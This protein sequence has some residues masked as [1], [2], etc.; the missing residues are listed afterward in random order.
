MAVRSN[1]T[2]DAFPGCVYDAYILAPAHE[3]GIS[4]VIQKPCDSSKASQ[5]WSISNPDAELVRLGAEHPL[6]D[7]FVQNACAQAP[8][9]EECEPAVSSLERE[10]KTR[11]A[12]NG[13]LSA[14]M[15]KLHPPASL[16]ELSLSD[17][18]L[19]RRRIASA[20]QM[21]STHRG[22]HL[23]GTRALQLDF[24][25]NDFGRAASQRRQQTAAMR[26]GLAQ[27]VN[28]MKEQ[29]T[30]SKAGGEA[31]PKAAPS[32]KPGATKAKADEKKPA[33]ASK[34]V[35]SAT[36]ERI[37][38]GRQRAA[39]TAAKASARRTGSPVAGHK[40]RTA[41]D[42]AG[43][44]EAMSERP[45]TSAR[46]AKSAWRP[47][48]VAVPGRKIGALSETVLQPQ[49]ERTPPHVP[50]QPAHATRVP[51]SSHSHTRKKS[52]QAYY[53]Q[54]RLKRATTAGAFLQMDDDLSHSDVEVKDL[55]AP[56]TEL[57]RLRLRH[58]RQGI[59]ASGR[60]SRPSLASASTSTSL[61][62]ERERERGVQKHRLGPPPAH[63]QGLEKRRSDLEEVDTRLA[64]GKIIYYVKNE[65]CYKLRIGYRIL[66]K[67]KP[68]IC[69]SPTFADAN[70][71]A[72]ESLG[73]TADFAED[74]VT[75][76]AA[77]VGTHG[78]SC[79]CPSGA[80][81]QVGEVSGSDCTTLACAGGVA[82]VCS[83]AGGVWSRR[84]VTC[85][86]AGA[87]L[88]RT[89]I[90][91]CACKQTWTYEGVTVNDFC[92]DPNGLGYEWC[93]VKDGCTAETA[94]LPTGPSNADWGYCA[95][96]P[97]DIMADEVHMRAEERR[98]ATLTKLDLAAYEGKYL[99]VYQEDHHQEGGARFTTEGC[100][101]KHTWTW[102]HDYPPVM[103]YCAANDG[104]HRPYI[105]QQEGVP[106]SAFE[107]CELEDYSC[108]VD[109]PE[110][111]LRYFGY[112][113]PEG[114]G[115]GNCYELIVGRGIFRKPNAP[116]ECK[117]SGF[118]YTCT[119]ESCN[120]K[121]MG[122]YDEEWSQDATHVYSG[123][124][125]NGTPTVMG[126]ECDGATA[127]PTVRVT[128]YADPE[129]TELYGT[130]RVDKTSCTFV[131]SLHKPANFT[132]PANIKTA[133][134]EPPPSGAYQD[135]TVCKYD[136][137]AHLNNVI[138]FATGRALYAYDPATSYCYKTLLGRSLTRYRVSSAD[139]CPG[140]LSTTL[141]ELSTQV[142][143]ARSG[144]Y[145]YRVAVGDSVK[146]WKET[147]SA[148]CN[149]EYWEETHGPNGS[150]SSNEEVY[151]LGLFAPDPTQPDKQFYRE[152]GSCGSNPDRST[153]V[154]IQNDPDITEVAFDVS[155]STPCA[156]TIQMSY[157]GPR[158]PVVTQEWEGFYFRHPAKPYNEPDATA[159]TAQLFS[160]ATGCEVVVSLEYRD[161]INEPSIEVVASDILPLEVVASDIRPHPFLPLERLFSK[162]SDHHDHRRRGEH[163]AS[164]VKTSLVETLSDL[165]S[166]L[167]PMLSLERGCSVAA[168]KVL[169]PFSS[170]VAAAEHAFA[171]LV[172]GEGKH[173]QVRYSSSLAM[174]LDESA[175]P[176]AVSITLTEGDCALS[177]SISGQMDDLKAGPMMSAFD[178][179]M[180]QSNI[181]IYSQESDYGG[182]IEGELEDS[183]RAQIAAAT[184]CCGHAADMLT[185]ED[186]TDDYGDD[187]M[188]EEQ[189][190]LVAGAGGGVQYCLRSASRVIQARSAH[191]DGLLAHFDPENLLAEG[192]N[193]FTSQCNAERLVLG[194][195]CNKSVELIDKTRKNLRDL[196]DSPIADWHAFI[197]GPFITEY[198]PAIYEQLEGISELKRTLTTLDTV[199]L[200]L[201]FLPGVGS[202][203][204]T[205]KRAVRAFKSVLS[206][207]EKVFKKFKLAISMVLESALTD[208][209]N[210]DKL[211]KVAFYAKRFLRELQAVVHIVNYV[212]STNPGK[213][214]AVCGAEV[215]ARYEVMVAT[216]Q[217]IVDDG[218]KVVED[219]AALLGRLADIGNF[220]TLPMWVG[221]WEFLD[222]FK[223]VLD[224]FS[225]LLNRPICFPLPWMKMEYK[226]FNYW[227]LEC[228]PWHSCRWKKYQT[229]LRVP[230]FYIK[231]FC[232][233]VQQI[234]NGLNN[235][236]QVVVDGLNW[237]VQQALDFLGIPEIPWP[238]L[239]LDALL[240]LLKININ[241]P[242]FPFHMPT[243]NHPLLGLLDCTM[244]KVPQEDENLERFGQMLLTGGG[245]LAGGGALER[246]R[247]TGRTNAQ[248]GRR[249]PNARP[250]PTAVSP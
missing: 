55:Q 86:G 217:K 80:V 166:D 179:A 11:K 157:P 240:E 173:E 192:G 221:F 250:L 68:G 176:G 223:I 163:K 57:Q 136:Y 202:L 42:K 146:Q 12:A 198:L 248:S 170:P 151:N 21:A 195:A 243:F 182:E 16:R 93:Y 186:E 181:E 127:T 139:D 4:T 75:E 164:A 222:F 149:N 143:Y 95:P 66:R 25:P 15:L 200:P 23:A 235:L 116:H 238:D 43:A 62:R 65:Y 172:V 155:E 207:A 244:Q 169:W 56:F 99:Y 46:P 60:S 123:G 120:Y 71:E 39:T 47:P 226:C 41:T 206:P 88:V 165:E 73:V 227:W 154:T 245:A 219:A 7:N 117:G 70:D 142:F 231:Q 32:Q 129:A 167:E 94:G 187:S 191:A 153:T 205:A 147:S 184:A 83:K 110:P 203:F 132:G 50:P 152:G 49:L 20:R 108:K 209:D 19:R 237:L 119:D 96:N 124:T 53:K 28:A 8:E 115:T 30:H 27:A 67:F 171:P 105:N 214:E 74:V 190:T 63:L 85:G 161:E 185:G 72:I 201:T 216:A 6:P 133:N 148:P 134:I 241:W 218:K 234:L 180:D 230:V 104:T 84:S 215:H 137:H 196:I 48:I 135:G 89:T 239:G 97:A 194:D 236:V 34:E 9:G 38:A 77:G 18:A 1:I 211:A 3:L 13:P 249:Q 22:R 92:G 220:F 125:T 51:P 140:V 141:A 212:Y 138:D 14:A 17:A 247:N 232:F 64:S 109:S 69:G 118:A 193:M 10:R 36:L 114:R 150:G 58:A 174:Y 159:N 162:H 145:C 131:V 210:V 156:Y 91:G 128:A 54:R 37:L 82:G 246:A 107:L 213:Q 100:A 229:C 90:K 121:V 78:G 98:L 130:V 76:N 242:A 228:S 188:A 233:T 24:R 113:G 35:L 33:S 122:I 102:S 106:S 5:Q 225:W 178:C 189:T 177:F 52:A 197:S 199:L 79:T 224:P 175:T 183:L 44:G 158:G 2:H 81:Y 101:C 103:R 40:T 160:D 168:L 26:G 208:T 87:A 111:N 59:G 45:S 126:D 112:C 29:A 144:S 31:A 204:S 61:E